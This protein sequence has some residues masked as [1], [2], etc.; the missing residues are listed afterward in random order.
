MSDLTHALSAYER[1]DPAGWVA[2]YRLMPGWL[3]WCVAAGGFILMLFGSERALF[4]GVAAP[5]GAAAG[6]FLVPLGTTLL[7]G[8]PLPE[9]VRLIAAGVLGGVGFA[10][11][12]ASLFFLAAIPAGLLSSRLL[13]G[14]DVLLAFLPAFVVG[15]A[16]AAVLY[17]QVGALL[18]AAVGAWGLVLGLLAGLTPWTSL[19]QTVA[20]MPWAVVAAA[21]CFALAG[22]ALQ[23]SRASPE[24]RAKRKQEQSLAQRKISEQKALEKRWSNYTPNRNK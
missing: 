2:L 11:P 20:A 16:V 14:S 10:L 12:P 24:E 23:L 9:Y 7:K 6:Y 15:G 8:G 13:S 22:A 3:G 5:L 19:P 17:R 21:G 4:R 18:T 1:L